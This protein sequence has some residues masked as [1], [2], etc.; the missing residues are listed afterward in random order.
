MRWGAICILIFS[1]AMAAG[2]RKS[3]DELNVQQA[4]AI[5]NQ[6][7][8]QAHMLLDS[9]FAS[10]AMADSMRAKYYYVRATTNYRLGN[11]PV[12]DSLLAFA[13]AYYMRSGDL[14][15]AVR[16]QL[17]DCARLHWVGL[18]DDA[19]DLL[20][21]LATNSELPEYLR[22]EA[23]LQQLNMACETYD[24]D[25]MM[26]GAI[27]M[28]ETDT[29]ALNIAR[30]HVL[31][32]ISHLYKHQYDSV[33]AP[34]EQAIA[35]VDHLP[36]S[37]YKAY[38]Y[39]TIGNIYAEAGANDAALRILQDIENNHL[40]FTDNY[41]YVLMRAS[42]AQALYNKRRYDDADRQ[43]DM[44]K[45]RLIATADLEEDVTHAGTVELMKIAVDAARTGML[46]TGDFEKLTNVRELILNRMNESR[47]SE[48]RSALLHHGRALQL[49]LKMQRQVLTAAIITSLLLA[50]WVVYLI[51]LTRRL[52]KSRKDLAAS[53]EEILRQKERV[54]ASERMKSEF[55]QSMSHEI[56]TPMNLIRG[57]SDLLAQDSELSQRNKMYASK[58][59]DGVDTLSHIIDNLL[60]MSTL[61]SMTEDDMEKEPVDICQLCAETVEDMQI[62]NKKGLHLIFEDDT[63]GKHLVETDRLYLQKILIELITN[64]IKFTQKGAIEVHCMVENG[65]HVIA[66]TDTG[67]GIPAS[68]HEWVFG[69]YTK[70]D[71]FVHGI[72]IGLYICRVICSKLGATIAIDASY[73]DGTRMLITLPD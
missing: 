16:C 61:I 25:R 9:V 66:V 39:I 5:M 38:V 28:L 8:L 35:A 50:L 34:I 73:T 64:A 32:A 72:G 54:E 17:L 31:I 36:M 42:I 52:S 51:V 71:Q 68:K 11:S 27:H 56:R 53:N 46:R 49:R 33:F 55:I 21:T 58:M 14:D 70:I 13:N 24:P 15:K 37:Y 1:L 10:D 18:G 48:H 57:F 23:R 40:D 26:L 63:N 29:V 41:T 65:H 62:Y 43:L 44:A 69:R 19:Y 59:I 67:I 60:D 3:H 20:D 12:G 7:P 45:E 22:N 6:D 47:E 30:Y 2:C 4:E